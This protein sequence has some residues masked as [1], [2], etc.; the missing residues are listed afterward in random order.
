MICN[1]IPEFS[2]RRSDRQMILR[3][4]MTSL[5]QC[6][7]VFQHRKSLGIRHVVFF[8]LLSGNRAN[9]SSENHLPIWPCQ[10]SGPPLLPACGG[11]GEVHGRIARKG[12]ISRK[13]HQGLDG[14]GPTQYHT[15]RPVSNS[16]S[17]IK[18]GLLHWIY[19]RLMLQTCMFINHALYNWLIYK[20]EDRDPKA[21][22]CLWRQLQKVCCHCHRD[23]D[24]S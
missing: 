5:L 15:I 10:N 22:R 12:G 3:L 17:Q 7:L 11:F 20:A 8:W 21:H 16:D 2:L 14:K 23:E 4:L 9:K 1:T 19:V 24:G 18:F 6:P 13:V